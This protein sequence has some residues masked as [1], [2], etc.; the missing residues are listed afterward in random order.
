MLILRSQL[1]L[2]LHYTVLYWNVFV[3]F[4]PI[5]ASFETSKIAGVWKTWK[6][7]QHFYVRSFSS[8]FTYSRRSTQNSLPLSV[9][10]CK[11]FQ[12]SI[13]FL[14][15]HLRVFTCKCPVFVSLLMQIDAE[16]LLWLTEKSRWQIL[17]SPLLKTLIKKQEFSPGWLEFM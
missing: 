10:V 16:L 3:I 15:M 6:T 13:E 1:V 2:V 14:S 7:Q 17:Q 9:N 4:C 11:S 12:S 8:Y 5:F